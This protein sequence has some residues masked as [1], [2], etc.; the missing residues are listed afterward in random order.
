MSRAARRHGRRLPAVLAGSVLIALLVAS[1]VHVGLI[2][3][4]LRGELMRQIQQDNDVIANAILELVA[5]LQP[6]AGSREEYLPMLQRICSGLR[7]PNGGF[8]CVADGEG[9]VLAGPE[10]LFGDGKELAAITFY[11]EEVPHSWAQ[12]PDG[13]AVHG[14]MIRDGAE[15]IVAALPLGD[16]G[17]RILVH[18]DMSL[19][20]QRAMSSA[21][22]LA[23]FNLIMALTVSFSVYLVSRHLVGRYE[24]RI[25][26]AEAGLV[27]T[28]ADL[29]SSNSRRRNLIHLLSHDVRNAVSAIRNMFLIAEATGPDAHE[30]VRR[31][32][33]DTLRMLDLVRATEA[34]ES[35]KTSL[36]LQPVSLRDALERSLHVIEPRRSDKSI[37]IN[38]RVP[39]G[40]TV[41]AEPTSLANSVLVNVLSNAVKF[42]PRGS[43]IDIDAEPSEQDVVVQIT[44]R[45]IGI[46]ADL[47]PRI[48]ETTGATTRRGTDGE[49]GTGF[50]MPLVKSF[51]KAYGG[52]VAISSVT[53]TPASGTTVAIRLPAARLGSA[54]T[55]APA[56]AAG[57]GDDGAETDDTAAGG[58]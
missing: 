15:E 54:A 18:Q 14:M 36:D 19:V 4:G 40:T 37:T 39:S 41:L 25:R 33:D 57:E 27:A 13:A 2:F 43:T 55:L 32:I 30:A 47:L 9:T 42:S 52:S 16:S 24:R 29:E 10:G 22:R 31:S 50:G 44:D 56:A 28:N 20:R 48:F 23:P 49:S 7:L 5:D 1:V 6:E 45:G 51:V 34:L 53:D 21:M 26:A 46:P 8:V 12:L 38:S 58:R 11:V 35:G 17:D 3:A